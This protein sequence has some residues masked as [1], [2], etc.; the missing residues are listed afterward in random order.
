M[1]AGVET[2]DL[3]EQEEGWSIR[4]VTLSTYPPALKGAV[5]RAVNYRMAGPCGLHFAE[6][7]VYLFL[8]NSLAEQPGSASVRLVM[9]EETGPEYMW[10]LDWIESKCAVKPWLFWGACGFTVRAACYVMS[11]PNQI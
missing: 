1:F 10:V 8:V 6:G 7:E 2:S 3:V 4:R 9:L 11:A 5:P